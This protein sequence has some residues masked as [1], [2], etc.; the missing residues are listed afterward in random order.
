VG[1]APTQPVVLGW[2]LLDAPRTE[3]AL[4]AALPLEGLDGWRVYLGLPM[5]GSRLPA[6]GV[7]ELMRLGSEDALLLIHKPVV[8][9]A[10]AEFGPALAELRDRLGLGSGPVGLLGGSIGAAVALQV[11]ATTDLDVRAAVLVSPVTRLAS[12]VEASERTFG[13]TYAWSEESRQVADQL[14]FVARAGELTRHEA[15]VLLVVGADDDPAFADSARHLREAL[16]SRA[17]LA[18]V[19]GMAHALAEE[20]GMEPAPQTA[21]AREVDRLAASWFARTLGAVAPAGGHV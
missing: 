7:A 13:V 17:E 11:L 18:V 20:P 3:T 12:A 21:A 14:D 4:A 8:D 2:H 10:V 15:D 5:S 19:P 1:H 16:G 9:G 6:G